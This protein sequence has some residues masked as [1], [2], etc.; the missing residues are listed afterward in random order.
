MRPVVLA[1]MRRDVSVV[2]AG[3]AGQ[4]IETVGGMLSTVLKD[5]GNNVFT[6]REF[7][8]RIRGGTN[9]LQ[10]RVSSHR[11]AAYCLRTDIAVPLDRTAIPH[12]AKYSRLQEST[13][14]VG[15]AEAVPEEYQRR[16]RVHLVEFTQM[17]R[18]LGSKVY[19][20]TIAAGVILTLFNADRDAGRAY[21]TERFAAKG[22]E[23]VQKNLEAYERG[24]MVGK[25]LTSEGLIFQIDREESV[26]EELI[27]SGTDAVSL[28]A[29]AGGCNFVSSYPMSPSTGVLTFLA[30]RSQEFGIV[31]D[32]AEDEIAAINKGIGAWYAGARAIVTTS[33]GG[34]ALMN[35]GLSLAGMTET[36][37]VIH[38]AQR[39]GPATGLPTR[40]E[41]GDLKHFLNAG[42]GEFA[43]AAFAPGTLH[44]AFHLTRRAFDLADRYQVPVA[45]LTDQF[46]LDSSWNVPMI[47]LSDMSTEKH[48]VETDDAYRRYRLT[49]DGVSPRGVPGH[50]A[51]LV[52]VDSDEHDED[53]HITEDLRVRSEMVRKRLHR[54]MELL[55]R[56]SLPPEVS[57]AKK[58]DR[59]IIA[60]GSNYH[61]M[62]EALEISGR[63]D[64]GLLHFRQVYPLHESV[65]GMLGDA[66]EVMIAENNAT[67][68]FAAVIHLET[69][70]RVP[71]SN[72][73][74]KYDGMPFSV[75]EV[76]G[77]LNR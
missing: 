63:T 71:D 33:G 21:L 20:N 12:L 4:G 61:V 13:A 39:P 53:G 19:S 17:A 6:T 58:P 47:D 74:L 26:K 51:G 18:E 60:W 16:D 46:L 44:D 24:V 73:L 75:E 35:E 8:S 22:P 11:V 57:G 27:L 31:V 59:L 34:F 38:L 5:S 28:G 67:S 64:T 40:T 30:Q 37:I 56:D 70:V 48:L 49:H 7:M 69:G 25:R 42:H 66:D 77:F 32:Q 14:I 65:A 15:E 43:R 10:V 9:T 62:R 76:V 29:I 50:G 55:R 54:K 23:V 36:P 68:Q 2:L 72:R 1:R 41:Q 52:V 45:I 3:A